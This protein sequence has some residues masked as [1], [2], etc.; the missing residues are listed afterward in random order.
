MCILKLGKNSLPFSFSFSSRLSPQLPLFIIFN[1]L[2]I[3]IITHICGK[4]REESTFF[5]FIGKILELCSHLLISLLLTYIVY[6][7][8]CHLDRHLYPPPCCEFPEGKNCILVLLLC[9]V[10]RSFLNDITWNGNARF[11]K[12][13]VFKSNTEA[14]VQTRKMQTKLVMIPLYTY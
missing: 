8:V 9:P 1:Y 11:A 6:I 4:E 12:K 2:Q 3:I 10:H 14:N 13:D 5:N 7:S